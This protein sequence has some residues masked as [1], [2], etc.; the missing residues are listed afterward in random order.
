[1]ISWQPFNPLL[2]ELQSLNG[3]FWK[4]LQ[5]LQQEVNQ[6]FERW[7]GAPGRGWAGG[8]PAVNIREDGDDLHDRS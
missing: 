7:T 1:M 2:N 6:S 8:Y 4:S 5:K 3:P